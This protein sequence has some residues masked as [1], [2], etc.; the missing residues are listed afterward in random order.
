MTDPLTGKTVPMKEYLPQQSAVQGTKEPG[1]TSG[2][3]YYDPKKI[4][5][6]MKKGKA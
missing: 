5:S 1:S 6:S 2:E 4:R 3:S